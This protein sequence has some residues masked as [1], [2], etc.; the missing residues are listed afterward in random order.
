MAIQDDDNEDLEELP[1]SEDEESSKVAAGIP[2]RIVY[3]AKEL[4]DLRESPFCN[5]KPEILND[6]F[7]DA[8]GRWNPNLWHS[9]LFNSS[10]GRRN[11]SNS[12]NKG[13]SRNYTFGSNARSCYEI[14]RRSYGIQYGN[15]RSREQVAAESYRSSVQE[16][17]EQSFCSLPQSSSA[18][19]LGQARTDSVPSESENAAISSVDSR[20]KRNVTFASAECSASAN[21]DYPQQAPS[22]LVTDQ[23]AVSTSHS[24]DESNVS[25]DN[26]SEG[27]PE[28]LSVSV[29]TTDAEFDFGNLEDLKKEYNE[30][31]S[32]ERPSGSTIEP[33]CSQS[34]A[35][36]QFFSANSR[37]GDKSQETPSSTRVL[38]LM[39]LEDIESG[40][41][42]DANLGTGVQTD[43]SDD[44]KAFK[45]LVD[46]VNKSSSDGLVV[47]SSDVLNESTLQNQSRVSQMFSQQQIVSANFH[48]GRKVPI[49]W[50][51]DKIL[52]FERAAMRN[53][54]PSHLESSVPVWNQNCLEKLSL[55]GESFSMTS[56]A[57]QRSVNNTFGSSSNE[58]SSATWS[59]MPHVLRQ[60]RERQLTNALFNDPATLLAQNLQHN[61][62]Q[63]MRQ[64]SE[65]LLYIQ[66]LQQERL[67]LTLAQQKLL[68]AKRN[69]GLMQSAAH[70]QSAAELQ[71]A[72][73][74]NERMELRLFQDQLRLQEHQRLTVPLNDLFMSVTRNAHSLNPLQ[75]QLN[76]GLRMRHPI[77]PGGINMRPQSMRP[78][79]PPPGLTPALQM[80]FQ[81]QLMGAM[82][83][84]QN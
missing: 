11:L 29:E 32:G 45:S 67:A 4:H 76:A 65:A 78:Q 58:E 63:I 33:G 56:L 51:S 53:A 36:D 16:P 37:S 47:Q 12:R 21:Q 34:T 28:W 8:N 81:R 14:S 73:R 71:E 57:S 79:Q 55:G 84:V 74:M 20:Q 10:K 44:L 49:T 42:P 60:N 62:Q 15:Y 23:N 50:N 31:V 68:D 39:T 9:S 54:A 61:S 17:V 38:P 72:I 77:P 30:Q 52:A 48:S 22:T 69:A 59:S 5:V 2:S 1:M 6:E 35:V 70:L 80:I 40:C 46:N 18:Y 64:Q 66:K 82:Q 13:G 24:A 25:V 75:T 27:E 83:H 3:T 43:A 26:R 19:E 7:F 41:H